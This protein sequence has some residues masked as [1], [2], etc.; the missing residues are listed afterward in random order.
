MT[1]GLETHNVVFNYEHERFKLDLRQITVDW[2]GLDQLGYATEEC[3]KELVI[4]ILR[5][6]E[7]LENSV[8]ELFQ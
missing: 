5:S 7:Q 4:R 8:Q 3:V 6:I 2:I 1:L